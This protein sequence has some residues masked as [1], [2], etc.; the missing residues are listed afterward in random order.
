VQA[1][2]DLGD[3]RIGELAKPDELLTGT[4]EAVVVRGETKSRE[5][6]TDFVDVIRVFRADDKV[7]VHEARP[8][9]HVKPYFD[10]WKDELDVWKVAC[11]ALPE[12]FF[13]V[14]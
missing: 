8:G 2:C 6:A 5:D 3:G 1:P 7:K 9:C 13:I 11:C 12:Y 10:V 14:V 4:V